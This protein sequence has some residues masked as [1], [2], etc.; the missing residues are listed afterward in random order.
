MSGVRPFVRADISSVVDLHRRV[1]SS[2]SPARRE[3]RDAHEAYFSELYF[4]N[5][6]CAEAS[7]SLVWEDGRGAVAGFLGVTTRAMSL[8]GQPLRAAVTSQFMVDAEARRRAPLA[9]VELVKALLAGPQD[10][11]LADEATEPAR[12][13]WEGLGGATA[14]LLSLQWARV[15]RPARFAV[16]RLAARNRLGRLARGAAPLCRPADGLAARMPSSPF[17]LTAT[18]LRAEDL[19]AATLRDCIA[20]AAADTALRPEYD[21]R[22]LKWLLEVL[23]GKR[24]CGGFHRTGL[25]D[26][27]GRLVGWYLAHLAP[28]GTGEVLQVGARGVALAPVLDHLFAR[29]WQLGVD[30]LYGRVEPARLRQLSERGCVFHHRGH[31]MLVHSGVPGVLEAIHRGDAFLTR[32]EGEW[33]LRFQGEHS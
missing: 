28:G 4:G 20:E 5:A 9:A 24:G 17:A 7:P 27:A 11:T 30:V 19:D 23:A 13:L 29:A 18:S 12:R 1:F 32:L 21:E 10:L 33:C 22:S 2:R 14:L 31:W 6:W 26:D 3:D 25:R 16:S 8:G 15:L